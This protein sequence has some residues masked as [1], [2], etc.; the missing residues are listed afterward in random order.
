LSLPFLM[1][2]SGPLTQVVKRSLTITN[3]N[4]QPVAFKV[5]TTAPKVSSDLP[6]ADERA[7]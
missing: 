5:K 7:R 1:P 4:S 3:Q 2:P 6:D